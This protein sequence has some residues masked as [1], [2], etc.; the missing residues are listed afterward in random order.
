MERSYLRDSKKGV[1]QEVLSVI[2]NDEKLLTKKNNLEIKYMIIKRNI[3]LQ[4]FFKKY[5]Y[6]LSFISL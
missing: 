5:I 3:F 4:K 2:L 6:I 1:N